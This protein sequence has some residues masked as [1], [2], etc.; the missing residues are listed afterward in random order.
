MYSIQDASND[1]DL[2]VLRKGAIQG[3]NFAF[4]DSH[5]NYHT[6]QDDPASCEKTPRTP[7][8]FNAFI[9]TSLTLI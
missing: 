5:Y 6:A 1:T 7:G 4:I 3:Y 9:T 8:L 2:T